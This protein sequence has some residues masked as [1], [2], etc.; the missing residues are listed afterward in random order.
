MYGPVVNGKKEKKKAW[1]K[2]GRSASEML[3]HVG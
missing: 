3:A 2:P 1:H